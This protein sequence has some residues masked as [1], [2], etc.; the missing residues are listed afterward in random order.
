MT[1][2][3]VIS[4]DWSAE[5]F[6]WWLFIRCLTRSFALFTR[7]TWEK[8]SRGWS[9]VSLIAPTPEQGSAARKK[10]KSASKRVRKG[11]LEMSWIVRR[12]LPPAQ[13][14]MPPRCVPRWEW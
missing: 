2:V 5:K 13:K 14:A 7:P 4:P 11:A 12:N 10:A 6:A 1:S 8:K 9:S 3:C